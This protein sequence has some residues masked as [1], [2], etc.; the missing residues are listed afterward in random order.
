MEVEWDYKITPN[1]WWE[2]KIVFKITNLLSANLNVLLKYNEL[3][4]T[5][6]LEEGKN[7]FWQRWQV[8]ESFGLGLNFNF[9]SKEPVENNLD[10]FV[11]ASVVKKRKKR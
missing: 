1:I 7:S 10:K 2:N 8:N 11:K 3:E 9:T 4:K 6:H 5:E